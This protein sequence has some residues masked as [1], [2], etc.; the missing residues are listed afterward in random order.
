VRLAEAGGRIKGKYAVF[1][2]GKEYE[3]MIYQ[4]GKETR[5]KLVIILDS[6]LPDIQTGSLYVIYAELKERGLRN[7]LKKI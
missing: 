3:L 6:E 4:Q 1:P 5:D 7:C 2:T